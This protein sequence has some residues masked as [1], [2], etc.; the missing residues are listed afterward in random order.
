VVIPYRRFGTTYQAPFSKVSMSK[1]KVHRGRILKS[2]IIAHL[3]LNVWLV[4]LINGCFSA[5]NNIRPHKICWQK[6]SFDA[7]TRYH[8]FVSHTCWVISCNIA[9]FNYQC[10]FL[11]GQPLV[12]QGLLIH[13]VSRSNATTYHLSVG[14][15]WTSDQ[16]IADTSIWQHTTLRTAR[17]LCPWWDSNPQSQ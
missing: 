10:L 15:P 13:E 2:N 3:L 9:R 7:E 4:L 12:G 11:E 1:K 6:E 14:L 5:D 17:H 8:I 16:L